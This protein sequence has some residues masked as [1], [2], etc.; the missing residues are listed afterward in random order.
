MSGAVLVTQHVIGH[1]GEG[2]CAKEGNERHKKNV[3]RERR[4]EKGGRWKREDS[5]EV[6][7]EG[8]GEKEEGGREGGGGREVGR[9][10]GGREKEE[11]GR[12]G[13]RKEGGREKREVGKRGRRVR[14]DEGG[15]G[16]LKMNKVRSF[17]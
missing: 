14:G 2:N 1:H 5:R 6:G 9:E 7:E 16:G 8:R 15:G 12:E 3:R 4:G 11:G 13:G 10:E 17:I